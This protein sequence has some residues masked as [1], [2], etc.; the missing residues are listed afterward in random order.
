M[1]NK[2][3]KIISQNSNKYYI[4]HTS[5]QYL[6]SVL[7]QFIFKYKKF[8]NN[9]TSFNPVF[10]V[11]DFDN[12]SIVL[13]FDNV[14]LKNIHTIINKYKNENE[15]DVNEE[16]C[17]NIINK[18][19]TVSIM[20]NTKSINKKEYLKEYYE[21]N[22]EKYVKDEDDVKKYYNDN[23]E[24]IKN[25]YKLLYDQKK[26]NENKRISMNINDFFDELENNSE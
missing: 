1:S 10:N 5:S 7:Q 9:T 26:K 25:T 4:G 11:I 19:E 18:L 22:K 13:L 2:I 17:E 24:K 14:E 16:T 3:Y 12:V 6:S 20:K 23:K 8:L 15:C 21:Q